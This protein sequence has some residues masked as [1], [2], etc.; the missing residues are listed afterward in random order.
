[1]LDSSNTSA[2]TRSS[3]LRSPVLAVLFGLAI[4][5]TAA[6]IWQFLSRPTETSL[7]LSGRVEGTPTE[8][9]TKISGRVESVA[10]R[11]GD[12]VNRGQVL[13]KLEGNEIT[14]ALQQAESRIVSA[15]QQEQQARNQIAMI[16]SQIQAVQ[17][18]SV[19][20]PPDIQGQAESVIAPLEA[21]LQQAE[22]QLNLVKL[23][24]DRLAQ[25]W[26]EG[27]VSKQQFDQAQLSYESVQ[28]TVAAIRRQ[29]DS[30]QSS[31]AAA[32]TSIPNPMNRTAGLSGLMQQR[33]QAIAQVQTAQTEIKNA[34]TT[35]QQIQAKLAYLAV[36]SP[37]DGVVT[38]RRVEPG[39]AVGNGKPLLSVTNLDSV[40]LRGF[41]PEGKLGKV[42]VGQQA[43]VYL[44]S[45]PEQSLTAR[46]A[47]IDS[48]ASFSPENT[49]N[50]GEQMVSVKLTINNLAG[51]A[52][53]GM[54]ARAE[55]ILDTGE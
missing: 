47:A 14:A 53:P 41:I 3:R 9:G 22:S 8:V 11:E 15:S 1:M 52:R 54:P 45:N 2:E 49:T 35:R 4:A 25:L 23:N 28:A 21:Q 7:R 50:R 26:Q 46:V 34:Q 10:V 42:R 13:V 51:Y 44:D 39:M 5:G 12:S 36:P 30:V 18:F 38:A 27:A 48:Q 17:Q 55:I 37:L 19:M 29:I 32:Q 20:Q 6:G 33:Q 24:R 43:K 16:D 40:Y 31:L